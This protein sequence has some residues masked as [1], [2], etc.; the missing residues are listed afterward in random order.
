MLRIDPMTAADVALALD[1]AAREGWNPGLQDAACFHAADSQGFFVAREAGRVVGFI[2]AV[3]YDAAFG[4]IG[5]YIVAPDCR[6][7]LVG[8]RLA[9]RALAYLGQRIIGVDGVLLKTKNYA[10]HGFCLRCKNIRHAGV[11]PHAAGNANIV[12]VQQVA[13]DA[14]RA[15]DR[16]HFPAPRARFL[17]QWLHAPGHHGYAWVQAGVLRGYGVVRPCRAGFK[18]GPLFADNATIADA[19]AGALG[20]HTQGA[21]V[22]FDTP[23]TNPAAVALARRYGMQEVFATARMYRGGP[24]ELPMEEIFGITS[25]E[26]G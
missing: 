24:P 19:L 12:P 5:L 8:I 11:L 25:F 16:R 23:D 3:A 10:A 18:L 26:L 15:Y 17:Q 21:T 2:S 7:R 4:F 9:Q 1:W 13:W 6:G 14:L 20:A 22:Y